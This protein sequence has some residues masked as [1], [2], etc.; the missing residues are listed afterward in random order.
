MEPENSMINTNNVSTPRNNL[1]FKTEILSLQ[2]SQIWPFLSVPNIALSPQ[3]TS[4]LLLPPNQ[5]S[6]TMRMEVVKRQP[7]LLGT[8]LDLEGKDPTGSMISA[9]SP[10]PQASASVERG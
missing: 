5:V 3:V 6:M 10:R 4:S 9:L 2:I 7:G 8:G 1:L